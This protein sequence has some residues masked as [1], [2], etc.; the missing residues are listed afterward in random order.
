VALREALR[1]A[2]A[3]LRAS[4]NRLCAIVA[5]YDACDPFDGSY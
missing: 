3:R 2:E 4:I 1:R 5:T